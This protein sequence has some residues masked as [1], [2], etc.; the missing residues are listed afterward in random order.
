[1]TLLIET[2]EAVFPK[3]SLTKSKWTWIC[4]SGHSLVTA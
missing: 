2:V 1:M 3:P 4:F